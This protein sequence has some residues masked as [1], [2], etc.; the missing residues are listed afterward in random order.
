MRMAP[1]KDPSIRWYNSPGQLT[2]V[3]H[4]TRMTGISVMGAVLPNRIRLTVMEPWEL[5]GRLSVTD[6]SDITISDQHGQK[7]LVII[8]PN[9]P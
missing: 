9:N 4:R 5:F 1:T 7:S 8:L 3:F 6:A 2:M